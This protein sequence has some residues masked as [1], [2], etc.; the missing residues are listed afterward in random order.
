MMRQL[1]IAALLLGIA[2]VSAI[3]DGPV[4]IAHRGASGYLPE[5]T[6]EA[7]AMAHAQGADYIEQDVVLTKD[8]AW[9]TDSRKPQL[10]SVSRTKDP[11]RAKVTTL[12]GV[13][14]RPDCLCG[15][16]TAGGVSR[17][18]RTG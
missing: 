14:A 16:Q 5:H 11:A 18:R 8:R 6:L 1:R 13:P 10:S 12:R 4:I 17:R 3:A 15:C 7:A 9:F 2:P